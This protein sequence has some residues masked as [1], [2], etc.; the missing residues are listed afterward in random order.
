MSLGDPYTRTGAD[1]DGR[2][3]IEWGVYGVP[4]TFVVDKR[5]V[6]RH[7]I[8][9]AI[10]TVIVESACCRW[11]ASP[12]RMSLVLAFSAGIVSF[13]SPCVLIVP[14]YVSYV[15]RERTAGGSR[16]LA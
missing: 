2:A 3:G 8:I 5:G 7:K 13:L 10:T 11:C 16:R 15:R 4:E 1:V 9:G 14:G 12:G 6:I